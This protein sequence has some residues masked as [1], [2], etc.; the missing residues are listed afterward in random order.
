MGKLVY[1]KQLII[2]PDRVIDSG[3][4]YVEGNRVV[5]VGLYDDLK[6]KYHPEVEIGSARH[7]VVPGFVNSHNHGKGVTDFQR[8]QLDDT[9]ETWKFRAYPP[10]DVYNDVLWSAIKQLES[11]ITSTMHNHDL[12]NADNYA[13][14]FARV[15]DAYEIA[16]LKVAFAPTLSNQNWFVYGD[17]ELFIRSLPDELQTLCRDRIER[18]GKFGT[19]QYF[20]A[21]EQLR[22]HRESHNVKIMHGPISPQWVDDESLKAVKRD[23][24]AHAMRIHIHLQQTSLQYLFGL[25]QYGKS[26]LGHLDD[27]GF[28]GG[29]VTCGH[30]VW[31]DEEDIRLLAKT[32]TTVTHHPACN[33][34]VRNGISPVF[35]LLQSGV[36]VG[37]GTDDKELGDDKDFLEEMRLVSKLHRIASSELDSPYLQPSDVFRMATVFGAET[38]G[39]EGVAGEIK[40]GYRAD[41]VLLRLDRISEPFI[42]PSQSPLE[43]LLYRAGT[44]DIDKV[45]VDGEVVVENGKVTHLDRESVVNALREG[46]TADYADKLESMNV[47][48]RKLRKHVAEW[49]ESWHGEFAALK[50]EPFYLVN[51]CR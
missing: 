24:D 11:G 22:T 29:N 15:L 5:E 38:L 25:K 30:A 19:K 18:S 33:L 17:N 9:L 35:A 39:L 28:L 27:L 32:G 16:G 51:R 47:K 42:S 46:L 48:Y 21:V 50:P 36:H 4:V 12:S 13:E 26:L 44:R 49:F 8:G 40:P 7:L 6:K 34:R 1:G 14:E 45:L 10:I 20:E 3:A 41:L 2:D 23:A 37:I 31:I 43:L